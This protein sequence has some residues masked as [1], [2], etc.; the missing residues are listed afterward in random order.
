MARGSYRLAADGAA[1]VERFA[2]APGP[3]GWRYVATREDEGTGAAR[4]RLDVVLDASGTPLRVHVEAAGWVLRGGA[5]GSELLWRR[6]DAEAGAVADG[7]TGSSPVWLLAA[8]RRCARQA[9][10][11]T[12]LRLLRL[13]DEALA[14]RLVDQAWSAAG[15]RRQGDLEVAGFEVTDLQTGERGAVHVAG[16]VVLDAPGVELTALDPP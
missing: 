4:G 15:T 7:F 10:P 8:A 9:Q 16:N 5:V 12:R 2:C 1:L 6:G 11:V 14:T 13:G 3:A